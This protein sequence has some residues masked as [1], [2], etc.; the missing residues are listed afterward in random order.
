MSEEQIIEI[1][2]RPR[3]G[4]RGV[5]QR[6]QPGA[7]V[8]RA[9]LGQIT[10]AINWVE[11]EATEDVIGIRG[12]PRVN[13]RKGDEGKKN[14]DQTP[15]D[16]FFAPRL[17]G[18]IVAKAAIA[19]RVSA[20]YNRPVNRSFKLFRLQQ[21]DSQLDD[22]QGRRAEIEKA[23]AE[24]EVVSEAKRAAEQAKTA[25]Q[26][27]QQAVRNA[28]EEAKAQQQHLE[29]NQ[30]RAYGGKVTNPKE[31][32][33]LEKEAEALTRRLNEL[34]NAELEKMMGLEETQAALKK[35]EENLESVVALREVEQG[36]LREEQNK[37]S[38]ELVRLKEERTT[39]T[40]GIAAED[41]ELYQSVRASKGG[42][43]VAKVQNKTCSA[44]GAEL[45]A[46]LAQAS[47]SPDEL[48]RCSSCKR[49]LYAP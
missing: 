41:V 44:C 23:L 35:A 28:E 12:E 37:L 21:V 3:A 31:L 6:E 36:T 14:E 45:S 27:A 49:I 46:S 25:T 2:S 29:Q 18:V 42:L 26:L 48:V 4:L 24:D 8:A 34:E 47:R 17:H 33:D 39:A 38:V 1:D 43:A 7:G 13:E 32:Q 40:K 9:H 5:W 15:H 10:I 11:Q 30:A 22:V 20:T 16:L 19:E